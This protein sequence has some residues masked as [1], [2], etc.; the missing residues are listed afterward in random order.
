MIRELVSKVYDADG[1]I[2]EIN[3]ILSD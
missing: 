2:L 1:Y 3:Q